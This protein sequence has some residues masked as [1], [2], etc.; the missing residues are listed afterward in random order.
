[1]SN[2]VLLQ[3]QS[4]DIRFD[5]TRYGAL[6]NGIAS[7]GFDL[8]ILQPN[9]PPGA[10]GD[11][12]AMALTDNPPVG[13]PFRVDFV[14]LGPG[15]PGSQPFLINQFDANG[16]FEAVIAQ[17]VTVPAAQVIPEPGTWL[18]TIAGFAATVVSRRKL[19]H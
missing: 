19:S 13:G 6:S 8:V 3:N 4:F 16:N 14:W 17:G 18:L 7:P 12:D 5:P 15:Q 11:Y 1:L 9:N 2:I 10:F